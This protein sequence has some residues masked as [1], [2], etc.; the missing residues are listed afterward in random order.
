MEK[1]FVCG[2]ERDEEEMLYCEPCDVSLCEDSDV[3]TRG[4]EDQNR[5]T[6]HDLG[7]RPLHTTN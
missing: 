4:H 1:C 6:P 7:D 3:C 2:A 5:N